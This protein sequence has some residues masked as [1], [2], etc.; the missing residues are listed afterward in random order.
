MRGGFKGVGEPSPLNPLKVTS[1]IE[2]YHVF[3]FRAVY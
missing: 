2:I 1:R 3:L